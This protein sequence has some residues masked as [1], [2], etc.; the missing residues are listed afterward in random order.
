MLLLRFAVARSEERDEMTFG[1]VGGAIALAG[2][3][4]CGFICT[5]SQQEMVDKVNDKL[6]TEERFDSLGWYS[7]KTQRLHREYSRL[8]PEGRLITK[9]RRLFAAMI[10]WLLL[11]V[12]LFAFT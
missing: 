3:A 9:T 4:V 12:I 2:V 8:Y 11:A 7:S 1:L 6:S 5:L 10:G